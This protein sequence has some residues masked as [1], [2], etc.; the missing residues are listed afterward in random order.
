MLVLQRQL[1]IHVLLRD[2]CEH[3]LLHRTKD[4]CFLSCSICTVCGSVEVLDHS[5]VHVDWLSFLAKVQDF[6]ASDQLAVVLLY[7]LLAL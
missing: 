3:S 4:L 7:R 1:W 2:A 5:V 6:C